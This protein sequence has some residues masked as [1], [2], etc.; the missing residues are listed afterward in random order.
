MDG[1]F[2]DDKSLQFV[3][4]ESYSTPV[5]PGQTIALMSVRVSPATDSGIPGTLGQ[6]EIVNRMQL[7]PQAAEALVNGSFLISVV[8]NGQMSPGV[9]NP[10]INL[11]AGIIT[12]FA[13]LAVGTSSLAQACDHSGNVQISGGETIYGFYAVNSAGSSNYSTIVADL[14]KIRDIGNSILGG[15][16]SNNAATTFYPDGPDVITL[17]ATNI[18]TATA[19]VATRLSW[20]EAQA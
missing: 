12:P 4:G 9:A 18:G 20:T 1:R 16:V 15:A 2:D 14:T 3:L 5:P 19:N 11:S 6:K 7:V 8:L 17:T 13:R 10:A